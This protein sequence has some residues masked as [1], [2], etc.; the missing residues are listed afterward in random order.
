MTWCNDLR[1]KFPRLFKHIKY[2][3]CNS[4]WERLIEEMCLDIIRYE[5]LV[6]DRINYNPVEFTQ[7]KIKFA[8]LR[9]YYNGGYDPSDGPI[10]TPY[11]FI[12]NVIMAYE[13]KSK[14]I[15]CIC[16]HQSEIDIKEGR[17]KT[18]YMKWKNIKYLG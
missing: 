11:T 1:K 4:G 16:G 17:C 18:C 15:C 9:V 2:I 3:E 10:I 7:V 8:E 12:R 14:Q 5:S 6:K 13:L